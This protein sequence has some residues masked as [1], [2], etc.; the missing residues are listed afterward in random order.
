MSR[1]SAQGTA[2]FTLFECLGDIIIPNPQNQFVVEHHFVAN[3]HPVVGQIRISNITGRFSNWFIKKVE[4]ITAKSALSFYSTLFDSLDDPIIAELCGA[5]N[6][7]VNLY[8]IYYLL[9]LQ[10]R[11]HVGKLL[12]DGAKNVFYVFD[13][14]SELRAVEVSWV[15]DGW[16]I[17]AAAVGYPSY[18]PM[19]TRIVARQSITKQL[20]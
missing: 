15:S 20:A 6:A 5:G 3:L 12:T 9:R 14:N 19:Q 11:G 18:I 2:S 16:H 10:S 1:F 13:I 7:A 8:D 4:D 17:D